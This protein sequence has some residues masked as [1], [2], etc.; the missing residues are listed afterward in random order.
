MLAGCNFLPGLR[1]SLDGRDPV[2]ETSG[3]MRGRL[4][5]D[6]SKAIPDLSGRKKEKKN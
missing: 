2:V 3:K 1:V 4:R 5:G 6:N